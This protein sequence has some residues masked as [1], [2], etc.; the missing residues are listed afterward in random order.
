MFICLKDFV[1]RKNNKFVQSL[2]HFF[3]G[4]QAD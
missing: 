3:Y 2:I 1:N 4:D